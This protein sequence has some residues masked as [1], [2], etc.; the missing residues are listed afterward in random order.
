MLFSVVGVSLQHGC[1]GPHP[2][3]DQLGKVVDGATP[4]KE[5]PP[6]AVSEASGNNTIHMSSIF[7]FDI[8]GKNI[9]QSNPILFLY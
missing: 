3:S 6:G 5:A 7:L 2:Q 9:N 4:C 8:M 1:Q